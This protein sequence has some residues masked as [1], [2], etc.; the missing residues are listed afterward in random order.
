MGARGRMYEGLKV[1]A[2]IKQELYTTKSRN[3]TYSGTHDI[4]KKESK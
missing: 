3:A 2:C 4:S 1:Q